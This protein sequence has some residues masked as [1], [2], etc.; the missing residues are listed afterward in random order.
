MNKF[1]DKAK[2]LGSFVVIFVIM[3]YLFSK[4]SI[5]IYL[6]NLLAGIVST[7]IFDWIAPKLGIEKHGAD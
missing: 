6:S 5:N 2:S 7:I 1:L 4:L 3:E